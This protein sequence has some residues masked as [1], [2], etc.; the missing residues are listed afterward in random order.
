MKKCVSIVSFSLLL[1]IF[2]FSCGNNP[3]NKKVDSGNA[4][5]SASVTSQWKL[6]AQMWTFHTFSFLTALDKVDSAGLRF[7]EAFQGQ[8]IGGD[9]NDTFGLSMRAESKT[10]LKTLLAQKGIQLLA[11]GVISPATVEEWK[12]NFEFAREMGL[13]YITAEPKK[14]QLDTIN[15]MAGEYNILVAI[16]D[17]PNPSPYAHPDSVLNAIKG[18]IN[19]GACADIGHW[20]R[21]GLDVVDCLKKL[22][23]RIYGVHLKDIQK[24]NQVEASDTTLGNG[25]LK[26]PEI[27]AEFKRQGFKGMFSIEHELH[28]QNNVPDVIYNREYFDKQISLLK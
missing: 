27:F 3:E 19:I 22:E 13:Q 21:N 26:M 4:S 12:Q 14:D 23:G 2:L 20:A 1:S 11:M 25:V 6:G 8:P 28:W 17:H 5:D 16:H 24:F 7:I 18:R 10:K 15:S 9:F